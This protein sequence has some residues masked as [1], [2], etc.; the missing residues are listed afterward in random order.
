M[1]AFRMAVGR[2][3][4]CMG[5]GAIATVRAS[6][7]SAAANAQRRPLSAGA[8]IEL[9]RNRMLLSP[10]RRVHSAAIARAPAPRPSTSGA[11]EVTKTA[12]G[13]A[14]VTLN[15]PDKLNALG[16]GFWPDCK[17]AFEELGAD[18]SVR[19]V[20][21]TGNGRSFCTGIDVG[22]L[23]TAPPLSAKVDPSRRA[24]LWRQ[25]VLPLQQAFTAI[26]DC[27]KPVIAAIH[28]HCYGAGIDMAAACDI[29][30]AAAD[31]KFSIKEVDIGLAADLGTL[32]RLPK[33]V[34]NDSIV[35]ELAYTARVFGAAEALSFGM[36]GRVCD[37]AD[38]TLAAAT[39]TAKLIASKSPI[40]VVGT[41]VNLNFSRDR[42]T[43]D[44]LDYVLQYNSV[45]LQTSDI[46][47]T[48]MAAATKRQ[49]V[50]DDIPSL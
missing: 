8:F 31:A 40:A 39:D 24:H 6:A 9:L 5:G 34:G 15:R 38:A 4:C 26:E 37:D 36:L 11:I 42:S 25:F 46:P 29:R 16:L 32:Q 3:Y 19:A 41:K 30:Y 50:Y 45:M 10:W 14:T 33:I 44:G 18:G 23:T 7:A 22:S 49:P 20:V 13:V 12:D 21:L 28:G 48:M 43:A 2:G 47:A 1:L 27:P 35:R 17:A